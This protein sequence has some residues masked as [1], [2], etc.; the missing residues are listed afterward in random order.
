ML[1][2]RISKSNVNY[3]TAL[4][5]YSKD[6]PLT[7]IEDTTGE[8]TRNVSGKGFTIKDLPTLLP[9]I[10]WDEFI[11]R[12]PAYRCSS[13]VL[14]AFN[15]AD[16][17][18]RTISPQDLALTETLYH[19]AGIASVMKH[20]TFKGPKA[21]V[22]P[23][24]TEAIKEIQ[25]QLSQAQAITL[26]V[27][28]ATRHEGLL[29]NA[30]LLKQSEAVI[31]LLDEKFYYIGYGEHTGFDKIKNFIFD[32]DD[33]FILDGGYGEHA[34]K[35]A[36]IQA[37]LTSYFDRWKDNNYHGDLLPAEEIGFRETAEERPVVMARD[38]LFAGAAVAGG[39]AALP[40]KERED[41]QPDNRF[42]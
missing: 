7:S 38:R 42:S 28:I 29:T 1:S 13:Y 2:Y 16:V 34:E 10:A 19:T 35:Y 41:D 17:M 22:D 37:V 36:F 40:Q 26:L 4:I 11:I 24:C 6:V 32:L 9:T 5:K 3:I 31:F 14:P 18:S 8:Y 30:M 21:H 39:V 15:R 25:P 33:G 27:H 23:N 20:E 12:G